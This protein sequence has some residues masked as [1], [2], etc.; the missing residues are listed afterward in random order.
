MPTLA[1]TAINA[2][3]SLTLTTLAAILLALGR[4][5]REDLLLAAFL[6]FVGTNYAAVAAGTPTKSLLAGT[7]AY[8]ALSLDP[9]LLLAFVASFPFRRRER[10]TN[11]LLAASATLAI[12][13]CA[14][15]LLSPATTLR[16]FSDASGR[17]VGFVLVSA[18]MTLSY[19][20]AAFLALRGV[21]GAPTP[22]LAARASWLLAAVAFT[23][24]TRLASVPIELGFDAGEWLA[25]SSA[26]RYA[27]ANAIERVIVAA[28][29]LGLAFAVA[30]RAPRERATLARRGLAF[31]T[32]GVAAVQATA[33]GAYVLHVETAIPYAARWIVFAAALVHGVL[34]HELTEIRR[35]YDRL[36]PIA[37]GSL[38]GLATALAAAS[39]LD[40]GG[41]EPRVTMVLRARNE[42][43]GAIG[44]VEAPHSAARDDAGVAALRQGS[45]GGRGRRRAAMR[46]CIGRPDAPVISLRAL[47]AAAGLA[48]AAPLGILA[49]MAASRVARS[50]P[51]GA[52]ARRLA[53][54][55]ATV[56]EAWTKG[57]PDRDEDRAIERERRRLGVGIDE[58]RTIEFIVRSERAEGSPLGPGDEPVPGLVIGRLLGEGAHGRVFAARSHTRGE[59][60]VVKE[61]R[62]GASSFS[63]E[64]ALIESRALAEVRHPAIVPLLDVHATPTLLLVL[65]SVDG[66]PLSTVLAAGPLGELATRSLLRALLEGLGAAHARGVVHR[67]VKPSNILIGVDGQAYLTDFGIAA[68]ANPASPRGT[69]RTFGTAASAAGTIGYMAPEQADGSAGPESDLYS[70][71]LV[72]IESLTGAMERDREPL[73]LHARLA[74]LPPPWRAFLSRA[75]A[76][77]PAARYRSAAEMREALLRL[78]P[79]HA[80]SHAEEVPRR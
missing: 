12:T 33:L 6:A 58:A 29:L 4:R 67:D 42:I 69:A 45:R 54:F 66:R 47:S 21:A 5:S 80:P 8:F 53:L 49:S 36:L 11:T 79:E 41:I 50:G 55:R 27:V 1:W 35:V 43:S 20:G 64:R 40:A 73:T 2:F 62:G 3:T 52:T 32:L 14:A 71:G 70:L 9:F 15:T 30:A 68:L 13:A 28:G 72:A 31:A 7:V 17:D 77:A 38:G 48:A 56:E 26:P 44:P 51:D 76:K 75:V 39:F 18:S 25:P 16:Y 78:E 24:I 19:A 74:S 63:R 60:V 22:P 61:I 23:T 65:K 46:G 59:G 57:M 34:A 10:V 37:A